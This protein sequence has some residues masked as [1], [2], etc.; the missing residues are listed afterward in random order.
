MDRFSQ[1]H[2]GVVMGS[3]L[4]LKLKSGYWDLCTPYSKWP[5]G[6]DDASRV[7]CELAG[8]LLLKGVRVF[9]PIA[10]SHAVAKTMSDTD[11]R[12]D[13]FWLWVDKPFFESA[14]GILI[15]KLPGWKES[16]G[17]AT[18]LDWAREHDKPRFLVDP[19]SL[20]WVKLP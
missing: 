16:A 4:D 20:N 11:P 6:L 10:H 17:I 7:A 3:I 12:A 8:R 15:A 5:H 19:G 13:D 1:D 9:S 18:E 2:K 14:H